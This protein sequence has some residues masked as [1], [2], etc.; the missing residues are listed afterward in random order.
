MGISYAND[1][2]TVTGGSMEDPYTMGDLDGDVTVGQY[3][4]PGGYGN[5]EYAVSKDLVIGSDS[6]DT[7]FD[8]SGSIIKMSAGKLLTIY[9]TALRG[10]RM[11]GTFGAN[12]S[13]SGVKPFVEE[14]LQKQRIERVRMLYCERVYLLDNSTGEWLAQGAAPHIVAVAEDNLVTDGP[15]S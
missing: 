11:G 3:V 15:Y 2:I 10:G 12:Q 9:T 5:K 4:T 6:V 8:I 14:T 7:F 1:T 13:S